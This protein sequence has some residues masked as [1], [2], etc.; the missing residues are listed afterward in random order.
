MPEQINL[1]PNE[2]SDTLPKISLIK[3]FKFGDIIIHLALTP[4]AALHLICQEL[5]PILQKIILQC[6]IASLANIC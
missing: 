6:N 3:P 1:T 5:R 4:F 2:I